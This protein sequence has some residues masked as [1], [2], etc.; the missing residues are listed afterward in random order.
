MLTKT[1]LGVTSGLLRATIPMRKIFRKL[2]DWVE[3]CERGDFAKI[4]NT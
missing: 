1:G 2:H 4:T 3:C